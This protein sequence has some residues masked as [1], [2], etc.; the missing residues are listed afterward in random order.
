M[1]PFLQFG[2]CNTKPRVQPPVYF[3]KRVQ[4]KDFGPFVISVF[5]SRIQNQNGIQ[6][7]WY[8]S[9]CE[10]KESN[11]GTTLY[12]GFEYPHKEHDPQQYAGKK[13]EA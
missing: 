11:Q 13:E 2:S 6:K 1:V 5:S 8:M 9:P 3:Y 12:T 4:G 7:C 10:R